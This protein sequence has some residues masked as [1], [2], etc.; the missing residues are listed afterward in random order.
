MALSIIGKAVAREIE[1][2]P[3]HYQGIAIDNYDVMPNHV[4]LLIKINKSDGAP[5]PL[6]RKRRARPGGY[7]GASRPTALIPAIATMI[8][9]KTN[10]TFS[11]DLWQPSYHDHIVRD[12]EDYQRIWQYIDE[13]P[14]KWTEN[15]YYT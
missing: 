5:G 11:S 9:K 12:E 7:V 14:A 1:E 4:H 6:A 13:N 3:S 15:A 10:K 2:T 8:K